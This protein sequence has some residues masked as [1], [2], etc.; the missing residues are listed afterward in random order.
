LTS[1]DLRQLAPG[2]AA[3]MAFAVVPGRTP[4]RRHTLARLGGMQA[5]P[6]SGR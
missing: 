5:N 4:H 2:W 1:K 6:L 3:L